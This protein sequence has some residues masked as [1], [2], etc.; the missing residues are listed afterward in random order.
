[1]IEDYE[2]YVDEPTTQLTEKEIE[3]HKLDSVEVKCF[4]IKHKET[5]TLDRLL[6]WKLRDHIIFYSQKYEEI[7]R[8]YEIRTG[9]V[10]DMSLFV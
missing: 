7:R 5:G 4:I 3:L 9:K 10:L 1:M 8:E 2:W 6:V